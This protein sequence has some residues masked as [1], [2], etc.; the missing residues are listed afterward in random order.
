M[1]DRR[2]HPRAP[3]YV[4]IEEIANGTRRILPAVDVGEY[5][6]RYLVPANGPHVQA[7]RVR[8]RFTLPGSSQPVEVTGRVLSEAPRRTMR[9]VAFEGVYPG[10]AAV[11]RRFV[12]R[13][14]PV[15]A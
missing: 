7:D 13:A 12:Q 5:G 15:A 4:P 3:L 6:M 10:T 2:G 8:L 1:L 11:I 14:D 9:S